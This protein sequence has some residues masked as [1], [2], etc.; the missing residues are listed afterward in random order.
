MGKVS[1][2]AICAVAAGVAV[3][4][5]SW[6]AWRVYSA[7]TTALT[8]VALAS[9]PAMLEA[10]DARTFAVTVDGKPSGSYTIATKV[11][12]DG[13]ET[14]TTV[15]ALKIKMLITY[16]YEL[17]S[18]EV[19]KKGQL[20]SVE[21]KSNDNGKRPTVSAVAADGKLTVTVD[22][23]VRQIGGDVITA[24][25]VRVPAADKARDA[26]Q[27]DPEDG[28]ETAVR[29]EP[30][31]DCKVILNGKE[32]E[33]K[34]FKMTGKNVDSEWWFDKDGRVIR[35]TMKTDGRKVVLELTGVK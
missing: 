1:K 2:R 9:A 24:T 28:A 30:L 21:A 14:I 3:T 25:G 11:D 7:R 33:G 22:R 32:I 4:T 29:V 34:R 13:T 16:T 6:L 18:T 27:F 17:N 23:T 12:A 26:I 19:W 15:A 31:G 8:A 35:Q 10:D 20:V 5:L